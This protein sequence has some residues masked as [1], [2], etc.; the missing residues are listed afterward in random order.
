M[1]DQTFEHR[2]S[3]G[4]SCK[5]EILNCPYKGRLSIVTQNGHNELEQW[6]DKDGQPE[7]RT[8]GVAEHHDIFHEYR[9]WFVREIIPTVAKNW[10]INVRVHIVGWRPHQQ[11]IWECAPG[12][13]SVERHTT[14]DP[15]TGA[16][17]L[18][19]GDG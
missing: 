2:F 7:P 14:V 6:Y 19:N 5:V 17:R 15:I 1:S 13:S 11:E 9:E 3:S 16:I 18:A 8:I 10:N 12:Q 4:E